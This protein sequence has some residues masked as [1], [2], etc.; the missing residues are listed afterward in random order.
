MQRHTFNISDDIDG[1]PIRY[2]IIY[3]DSSNKKL[4]SMDIIEASS[5]SCEEDVCTHMF[6]V[7]SSSCS[8]STD[9]SVSVFATNILGDGPHSAA[10]QIGLMY[11]ICVYNII[12]INFF[13]LIVVEAVLGPL[14]EHHQPNS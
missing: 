4:C 9:I 10:I 1:S 13:I 3:S 7:S 12:I 5:D 11:T 8:P 2:T 6:D 14:N